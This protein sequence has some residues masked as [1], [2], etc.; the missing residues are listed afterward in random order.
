MSRSR[1]PRTP[2]ARPEGPAPLTGW[3]RR[4]RP[5]PR[6]AARCSSG[7]SRSTAPAL[8]GSESQR[9]LARSHQ[10]SRETGSARRP[11]RRLA[12]PRPA[13]L[14]SP[15][16]PE[17]WWPDRDSRQSVRRRAPRKA[18]AV[19]GRAAGRGGEG[20]VG[21]SLRAA[22]VKRGLRPR[23]EPTAG[24][25]GAGGVEAAGRGRARGA[26]AAG[27]RPVPAPPAA[28]P[29][30]HQGGHQVGAERRRRGRGRAGGD[31]GRGRPRGPSHVDASCAGI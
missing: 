31:P 8:P 1:A 11:I 21:P 24:G 6:A 23:R 7:P 26:P 16:P 18:G 30:A 22:A 2:D 14:Q 9:N 5:A 27:A 20:N 28:L 10:L 15:P 12:A 17:G 3:P 4:P 13:E 29:G 25:D 19:P